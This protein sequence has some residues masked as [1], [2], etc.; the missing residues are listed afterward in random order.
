LTVAYCDGRRAVAKKSQ[1][2]L[3]SEF[4][5]KFQRKAPLFLDV[6]E[7]PYNTKWDKPTVVSVPKTGVIHSAVSCDGRTDGHQATAFIALCMCVAR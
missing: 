3:S 4:G 1:N 6:P 2:L 7:F 5:T